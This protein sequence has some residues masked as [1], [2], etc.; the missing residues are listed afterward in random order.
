MK[1]LYKQ[2]LPKIGVD[3]SLSKMYRHGSAKCL[4][5]GLPDM[6]VEKPISKINTLL[7]N[8]QINSMV[9]KHLRVSIE[10][11][12]LEIGTDIPFTHC[13]YSKFVSL[14]TGSWVKSLWKTLSSLPLRIQFQQTCKLI[15]QRKNDRLLM[16]TIIDLNCYTQQ[17]LEAINRVWLYL[18]AVTLIDI[19]TGNVHT[20]SSSMLGPDAKPLSNSYEWPI[21]RPTTGDYTTWSQALDCLRG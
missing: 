11:L 8:Y 12:Q 1:P 21:S 14:A 17:Q 10:E 15:L 18:H 9:S 6:Y 20:I 19:F 16:P 3:G 2:L 13:S 5:L 7:S 4:G